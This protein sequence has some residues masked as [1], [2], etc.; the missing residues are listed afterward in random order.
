MHS[1]PAFTPDCRI[2]IGFD[3]TLEFSEN[4]SVTS[5]YDGHHIAIY[6]SEFDAC[7]KRYVPHQG[8][9]LLCVMM[10]SSQI[11]T[12]THTQRGSQLVTVTQPARKIA[13]QS[14]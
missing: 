2:K 6:L 3:Q 13:S 8:S 14:N 10:D 1:S 9:M 12:H 4:G 11:N 5:A 7:Y